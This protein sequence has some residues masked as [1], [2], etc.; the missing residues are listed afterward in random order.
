VCDAERALYMIEHQDV[1]PD[2]TIVNAI[3]ILLD[4]VQA[5]S[6]PL[7]DRHTKALYSMAD[8]CTFDRDIS[9]FFGNPGTS[10]RDVMEAMHW[11]LG[12]V[13]AKS[14]LAESAA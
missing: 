5:V 2:A 1:D 13:L 8:H 14:F 7:P 6:V 4:L 12:A 9:S 3:N 11:C 10:R